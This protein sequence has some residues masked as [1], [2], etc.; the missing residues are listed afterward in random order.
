MVDWLYDEWSRHFS[1]FSRVGGLSE[2]VKCSKKDQMLREKTLLLDM[3][4]KTWLTVNIL[5]YLDSQVG[6]LAEHLT[7]GVCTCTQ[8]ESTE[9]ITQLYSEQRLSCAGML[10]LYLCDI[11][12]LIHCLF[13]ASWW[14]TAKY[15]VNASFLFARMDQKLDTRYM[16]IQ[17]LWKLR[18]NLPVWTFSYLRI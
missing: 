7:M 2:L 10:A 11:M 13:C 3:L 5:I 9:Y 18:A 6:W 17:H 8:S 12:R 16:K 1:A 14:D 4:E 15:F